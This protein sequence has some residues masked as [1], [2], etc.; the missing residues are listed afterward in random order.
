MT[1]ESSLDTMKHEGIGRNLEF[2]HSRTSSVTTSW[3]VDWTE[4]FIS[5]DLWQNFFDANR[6]RLS[7][8]NVLVERQ[9]VTIS[10]PKAMELERLFYLGSEKADEDVGKYGEGFKV[11]TVC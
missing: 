4:E 8:I 2:R 1:S 7:E 11:A 9:T 3:G 6:D 5:R 10:A